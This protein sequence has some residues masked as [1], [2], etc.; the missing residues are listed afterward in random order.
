[1]V[2]CSL[3]TFNFKQASGKLQQMKNEIAVKA[4]VVKENLISFP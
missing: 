2:L 3:F 1:M 4:L